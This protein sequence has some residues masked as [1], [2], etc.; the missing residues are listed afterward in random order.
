MKRRRFVAYST[1][2]SLSTSFF[3][4]TG[5]FEAGN[6][7]ASPKLLSMLGND[8]AILEIGQAY[9]A[10]YVLEDSV[11]VLKERLHTSLD[12]HASVASIENRIKLDFEEGEVVCIKGWVL[13]ITEARQ[14][15]LYSLLH[16]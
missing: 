12:H 8:Q 7:L 5:L 16:S 13:S 2:A 6:K 9:I 10:E 11:I 1:L 14:C 4:P 15:A 3:W